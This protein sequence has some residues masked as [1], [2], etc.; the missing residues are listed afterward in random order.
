MI[1]LSDSNSAITDLILSALVDFSTIQGAPASLLFAHVHPYYGQIHLY[2]SLDENA[3]PY[4]DLIGTI[5]DYIVDLNDWAEQSSSQDAKELTIQLPNGTAVKPADFNDFTVI[6][7]K[8]VNDVV[9][10]LIPR[11]PPFL[12]PKRVIVATEA[13]EFVNEWTPPPGELNTS[14]DSPIELPPP[15]P[16]RP[17]M[18]SPW[19]GLN[20]KGPNPSFGR[21]SRNG[22]SA[23]TGQPASEAKHDVGEQFAPPT[24]P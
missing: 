6:T 10:S 21:R 12:K 14:G 11:L 15:S 24:G 3:D 13:G 1:I 9:E 4:D 22:E 19:S 16:P 23:T 7:G 20:Y 5:I 2:L 17:P 8:H 18:P